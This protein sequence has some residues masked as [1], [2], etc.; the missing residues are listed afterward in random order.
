MLSTNSAD[1]ATRASIRSELDSNI[2]VAAGAGTGKT[3][4]LVSRILALIESGVGMDRIVAITFTRAAA[5]E[6]RLRIREGLAARILEGDATDALRNA[7]ANVDTAAFKTIDSYVQSLLSE[8]PLEAGLP[9]RVEVQSTEDEVQAFTDQWR[10]WVNRQLKTDSEFVE[11]LGRAMPLGMRKPLG[12][13]R[14]IAEDINKRHGLLS[15][16]QVSEDSGSE[17]VDASDAVDQLGSMISGLRAMKA[18][19]K[20]HDDKLYLKIE[21]I[22]YWWSGVSRQSWSTEAEAMQILANAPVMRA[23]RVG[24]KGAWKIEVDQVRSAVSA[25]DT[26]VTGVLSMLRDQ[27]ARRMFNYA[28][29]FV[30]E[31]LVATRASEGELTFHDGISHGVD[32]LRRNDGVRRAVQRKHSHVLVDEFQDTD[33]MQVELVELLT[34]P[35]GGDEFRSGSLFC[36]GDPKQSIYRFRGADAAVSGS[37]MDRIGAG[38]AGNVLTLAENH[39]SSAGI[40]AWVN[41]VIGEWMASERGLGQAEW[42]P[43]DAD[44]NALKSEI[45]GEVYLFGDADGHATEPIRGDAE[46]LDVAQIALEVANG[47]YAVRDADGSPRPSRAGD[48]AIIARRRGT[49]QKYVDELSEVG[50]DYVEQRDDVYFRSQMLRDAINCMTAIDDPTNQV[51]VL[52]ALRCHWFGCSDVDLLEWTESG[53]KFE[54]ASDQDGNMSDGPVWESIETLRRYHRQH[55]SVMPST[56]LERLIRERQVRELCLLM[57]DPA[58][59]LM[60]L[61]ATLE[62]IRGFEIDGAS[63]LREC[64]R[65][66]VAKRDSGDTLRLVPTRS[67][68]LDKVRL[69]TTHQAKGLEFPIVVVADTDI[70]PRASTEQLQMS[71]GAR[72]DDQGSSSQRFA[73]RLGSGAGSG[74]RATYFYVGDHKWVAERGKAADA[75]EMTRLYYV[76]ATRAKDVL[77]VS[78]H[79]RSTKSASLR[80]WGQISK[81]SAQCPN[82]WRQWQLDP[83]AI[84]ATTSSG[85]PR[86]V[87]PEY[88]AQQF[89]TDEDWHRRYAM[90]VAEASRSSVVSPSSLHADREE[91]GA[92]RD[93]A[94][95]AESMEPDARQ[96]RGRAATDLGRAV[97]AGMQQAIESGIRDDALIEQ[98]AARQSEVHGVAPYVDEVT[99]LM[100]AT[101]QIPLISDIMNLPASKRWVEVGVAGAARDGSDIVYDGQIDLLY[102]L[103]DGRL[104]VVDFKTDREFG[105]NVAEMARAYEPQLRAY[106][107]AVESATGIEVLESR[108]VFSRLAM[109]DPSRADYCWTYSS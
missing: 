61:E 62:Q 49:W 30:K 95:Q 99:K 76:A 63:S 13:L 40:I 59:E 93:K 20:S 48:L 105:R 4:S 33:P 28:L 64:V 37:V 29:E 24:S 22:E 79:H 71:P 41:A 83:N 108:V 65:K 102:Q 91:G 103:D 12:M 86:S 73:V 56:L 90:T 52:G 53:G 82:L 84:Q 68:D 7:L 17:A 35:V 23:G 92:P 34:V 106:A 98:I 97:H 78:R 100:R 10:D 38:D 43:L 81:Y 14:G 45:R 15:P 6:L 19:C 16:V 47:K 9:P 89:D 96:G 85:E 5:A 25:A 104:A 107:E 2:F 36:V 50:I 58:T 8:Y 31:E 75:L 21:D 80:P 77:F 1:E 3:T 42:S 67:T 26:H 94:P 57:D 44:D 109:S 69:M 74:G 18:Q 87:G 51:A 27:V 39:R 72:G 32:L 54:Y 66:L 46:A 101:L 60:T 70:V 11:M 88:G 55:D